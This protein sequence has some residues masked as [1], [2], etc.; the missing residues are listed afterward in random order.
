MRI[1]ILLSPLFS[2]LFTTTTHSMEQHQKTLFSILPPEL[3]YVIFLHC[4]EQPNVKLVCKQ[5]D[6]LCKDAQSA[7]KIYIDRLCISAQKTETT[8]FENLLRQNSVCSRYVKQSICSAL[9]CENTF[10]NNRIIYKDV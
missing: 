3:I 5:L 9:Q 8:E 7:Q 1:T 2:L 10:K 4:N 6:E